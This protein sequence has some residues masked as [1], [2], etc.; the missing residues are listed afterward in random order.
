MTRSGP[1]LVALDLGTGSVRAHLASLLDGEWLYRITGRNLDPEIFLAKLLWIRR[2]EPE[3]YI[4]TRCFV[5]TK[6]D[7]IPAGF[8]SRVSRIMRD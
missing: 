1:F 4:R 5:G 2:H 8:A 7:V 3:R 6:D